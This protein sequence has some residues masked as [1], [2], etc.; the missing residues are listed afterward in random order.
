MLAHVRGRDDGLVVVRPLLKRA[1]RFADLLESG[2]D[3]QAFTALPRGELIGRPFGAPAFL[4][5][6]RRQ[7][8]RSVEPG[9]R[10]PEVRNCRDKRER[11]E[12]GGGVMTGAHHNTGISDLLII[13]Q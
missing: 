1:P 3:D 11:G 8:G 2:H 7:L 9:E 4:E 10:E 12:I 13:N 6:I 5:A